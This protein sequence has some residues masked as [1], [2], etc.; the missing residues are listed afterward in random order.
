MVSGAGV[1]N[2]PGLDRYTEKCC[3]KGRYQGLAGRQLMD[4]LFSSSVDPS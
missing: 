1:K 3:A 2:D 4:L